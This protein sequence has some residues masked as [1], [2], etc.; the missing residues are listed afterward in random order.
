M[1]VCVLFELLNIKSVTEEFLFNRTNSMIDTLMKYFN[2]KDSTEKAKAHIMEKLFDTLRNKKSK[3][4]Y[5][6]LFTAKE[7]SILLNMY[8][9]QYI[10]LRF[11]ALRPSCFMMS[12]ARNHMP[13]ILAV[14]IEIKIFR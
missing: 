6:T 13:Q 9:Y 12:E 14:Y 11:L 7:V 5:A 1:C 4:K 8:I 10:V 3:T 2:V